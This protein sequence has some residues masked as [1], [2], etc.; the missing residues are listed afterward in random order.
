[1]TVMPEHVDWREREYISQYALQ[2]LNL[3]IQKGGVAA[4]ADGDVTGT[5]ERQNADGTTEQIST[6]VAV[7][8][9]PGLYTI[10][11][12][13]Q[14]TATPGDYLLTW[15]YTIDGFEE[16]YPVFLVVGPA[17]PH[18]DQ[19]PDDMKQIVEHV[20]FRFA[21]LF[22]SPGGGPNLQ[23]YFQT[24]W[25][26]GRMAQL[27]GVAL[28]RLNTEAQ[29]YMTYTVDGRDGAQFP[30]QMWG[31]LLE[32]A[33]YIEAIKHLMRS[34]VEQPS[35]QGAGSVARLDR[36]DYLDRW[37]SIADAEEDMITGQLDSFKISQMGLGR[38]KVLVSGGTYGRYSPTRVAGSIAARPRY[39]TRM[40]VVIGLLLALCL[41]TLHPH[42]TSPASQ[43]QSPTSGH[44]SISQQARMAAGL[45]PSRSS[46]TRGTAS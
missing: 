3:A 22:D 45:G 14:D 4:S 34:Y 20:W 32:T 30:V 23:T 7:E 33:L 37:R 27:L 41:A 12:R 24:H 2:Q 31:S 40:Y 15:N 6:P 8:T 21:D 11:L 19:L 5:W 38:P 46:S 39:W 44:A 35:F 1:M 10:T 26:R 18:Y 16:N 25:S 36:R 9:E 17:N 13:G 43:I 28:G 42:G 29:P